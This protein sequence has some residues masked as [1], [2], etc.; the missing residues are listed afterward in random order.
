MDQ[1]AGRC[2]MW[3]VELELVKNQANSFSKFSKFKLG[4]NL[5]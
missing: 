1:I 4:N 5:V 3:I 2:I